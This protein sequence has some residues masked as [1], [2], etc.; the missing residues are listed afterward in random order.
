V[1]EQQTRRRQRRVRYEANVYIRGSRQERP[2]VARAQNLS[3]EGI[4]VTAERLPRAGEEVECR[5]LLGGRRTKLRGRVAWVNPESTPAPDQ[6][7]GGGIHFL[8]VERED[9]ALL[10][11]L[12]ED[13][14]DGPEPVEVWM[15]GLEQPLRMRALIGTDEVKLGMRLPRLAVGMPVRIAFTHRGVAENRRGAVTAV[16]FLPG[17]GDTLARIAVQVST[18]RPKEGAGTISVEVDGAGGYEVLATEA[19]GD[20]ESM[21]IDLAALSQL[22]AVA[23]G[24]AQPSASAPAAASAPAVQAPA[25]NV[26]SDVTQV[27]P[28]Q[29][30]AVAMWRLRALFARRHWRRWAVA[31]GVAVLAVVLALLLRT[32]A[33]PPLAVPP[34][35][36][37]P[38]APPPAPPPP[39]IEQLPQRAAPVEA[40]P[41][42]RPKLRRRRPP[43]AP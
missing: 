23:P 32:S 28:P 34:A 38:Q 26:P 1:E 31:G 43:P 37:V 27:V 33:A 18:P 20:S 36:P 11:R 39:V 24:P 21:L 14:S 12:I 10:N 35:R 41:P 42:A 3:T 8:S 22:P 16:R 29:P 30:V 6:T 25:L 17:D 40:P 2:F 5:L 9:R 4:A 13:A 19:V 7:T 15:P